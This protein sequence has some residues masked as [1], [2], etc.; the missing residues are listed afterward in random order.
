M[1]LFSIFKKKPGGTKLGNL[2]RKVAG[3]PLP[4]TPTQ[5]ELDAYAA[6]EAAA[7]AAIM[8]AAAAVPPATKVGGIVGTITGVGGAIAGVVNQ[9]GGAA[10][11]A[12]NLATKEWLKK[13]WWIIALPGGLILTLIFVLIFKK[14]G[15]R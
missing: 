7:N 5:A 8:A 13:N 12:A 10:G 4:P 1:G 11:D 14:K 9:L 15:R 3:K 6:E 2:L